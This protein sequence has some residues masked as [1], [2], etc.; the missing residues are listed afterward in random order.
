MTINL[1]KI[2]KL[3]TYFFVALT[4]LF[5]FYFK[6]Y[7]GDN[8]DINSSKIMGIDVS[9]HQKEIDWD[10]VNERLVHFVYIKA[11]EGGDFK[12]KR[13]NQNWEE[14]RDEG[15]KVGAYHFFKSCK[16]G[17]EQANNF[18]DS[19]P[20]EID[21]LPP[22]IDLEFL[23]NCDT[24]KT[25]EQIVQDIVVIEDRLYKYYG[26]RPIFYTNNHFYD[27]Y[28]IGKFLDNP[29]W[30][31]DIHNKKPKII[32]DREWLIWQFSHT[33]KIKGIDTDVDLNY[34]NGSKDEF[35]KWAK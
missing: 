12:D 22:A 19:V 4:I 3:I 17:E 10:D 20:K 14:A 8:D 21:S 11:T 16:S 27:R 1:E 2:L 35:K 24:N 28:L 31:S 9:N 5:Y 18:I 7:L 25:D 26:K 6:G 29:I 33:G 30:Y 32:D 13:F 23:G 15:F 34:F